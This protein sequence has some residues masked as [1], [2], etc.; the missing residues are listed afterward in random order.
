MHTRKKKKSNKPFFTALRGLPSFATVDG[1]AVSSPVSLPLDCSLA[2][3][4]AS[5]GETLPQTLKNKQICNLSLQRDTI[6]T[7][8]ESCAKISCEDC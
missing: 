4:S 2:V 3:E 8:K 5:D 7:R 6:L 1:L